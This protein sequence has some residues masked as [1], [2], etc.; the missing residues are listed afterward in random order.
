[1][2]DSHMTRSLLASLL[3]DERAVLGERVFCE[4]E[5]AFN[6][7]AIATLPPAGALTRLNGRNEAVLRALTMLEEHDESPAEDAERAEFHR[8][9]GK[10]NLVMELLAE[11]VRERSVAANPVPMRFSAEGVCWAAPRECVPGT[12]LVTEWWVMPAWPV[13]L[14]LYAEVASNRP[15]ENGFVV[16]A[17]LVGVSDTVKDW[18]EK[19][20]FRRH[21]RAIAQQRITRAVDAAV[22]MSVD[23]PPP[24]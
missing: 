7:S 15:A 2:P 23:G 11:L 16:C 3:P 17:R 22:S 19:L 9:E 24:A 21:R 14:R 6:W 13:A 12:L 4:D 5:L 18:L 20:V 8:L 1:M 10:I